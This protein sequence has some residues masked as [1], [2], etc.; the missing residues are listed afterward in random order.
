MRYIYVKYTSYLTIWGTAEIDE[1][2]LNIVI[3]NLSNDNIITVGDGSVNRGRASHSRCIARKSDFHIILQGAGPSDGNPS[4][5]TS[6]RPE[7]IGCI[8]VSSLLHLICTATHISDK[9]VPHY[10][11]CD[12]LVSNS[13]SKHWHATK[14]VIND[15]IDV[16]IENSRLLR[17]IPITVPPTHVHGHQDRHK[18]FEELD[19]VVKLNV[20]MDTLAVYFLDH[21]PPNLEPSPI[22]L[23]FP[24]QQIAIKIDNKLVTS[25]IETE[26][27]YN[28]KKTEI[29][30][31]FYL[32]YGIPRHM[33]DTID[34]TC[35]N[36]V[37]SKHN[38][39]TRLVKRFHYQWDTLA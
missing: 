17:K 25:D 20:H 21:N 22:P 34:R 5:L 29:K 4:T 32:Q 6:V 11:D 7:T 16:I 19:D 26:L 2:V 33:F 27:V 23:L 1:A 37:L 30:T 31:Y 8:A 13:S 14:H 12:A 38:K 9:S 18:K 10:T 35:F 28:Q 36:Y 3:F 39:R 15:D 24:S